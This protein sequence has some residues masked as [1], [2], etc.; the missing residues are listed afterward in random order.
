M[1]AG[2][3]GP[4]GHLAVHHAGWDFNKEAACATTL[5][6]RLGAIT[7]SAII[8]PIGCALKY[9]ALVSVLCNIC[10]VF[11]YLFSNRLPISL[12][13][14][15]TRKN[16]IV[17]TSLSSA[18]LFIL[19][20]LLKWN[21]TE[22]LCLYSRII[23]KEPIFLYIYFESVTMVSFNSLLSGEIIDFYYESLL[24]IVFLLFLEMQNCTEFFFHLFPLTVTES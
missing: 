23:I 22:M 8:P 4:G 15:R 9:I 20:R 11:K 3:F 6:Q 17:Y 7:A 10:L 16:V 14:M 18:V 12:R 2:T 24:F 1:A 21:K 19:R 5:N 13:I